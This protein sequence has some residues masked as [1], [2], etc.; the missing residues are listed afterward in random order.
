MWIFFL[1][2]CL[3][4][5]YYNVHQNFLISFEKIAVK[6][7]AFWSIDNNPDLVFGKLFRA[8]T[9]RKSNTY[10]NVASIFIPKGEI[11]LTCVD[12]EKYRFSCFAHD[13]WTVNSL[14][15]PKNYDL[16]ELIKFLVVAHEL[17]ACFCVVQK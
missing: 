2:E 13:F 4:W 17:I 12:F 1:K 10:L 11:A 7:Q 8:P 6:L 3:G 16:W 9:S 15:E 5:G 14:M